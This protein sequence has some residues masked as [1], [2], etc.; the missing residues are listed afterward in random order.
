MTFTGTSVATIAAST[1]RV[2]LV[3][4]AAIETSPGRG[5][6]L[7]RLLFTL[8]TSPPS[9]A[10]PLR[11]T[12]TLPCPP[13]RIFVCTERLLRMGFLINTTR[14]FVTPPYLAIIVTPVSA[15]V[16]MVVTLIDRSVA[17]PAT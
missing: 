14:D 12:V 8:T 5:R 10:R 17:P 6:M 16:G 2:T 13:A 11:R 15:A 4:P 7:G 9:G 1:I 3:R